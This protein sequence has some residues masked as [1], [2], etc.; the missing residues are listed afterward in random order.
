GPGTIWASPRKGITTLL[1][2]SRGSVGAMRI[3]AAALLGSMAV[4]AQPEV[5]R[6]LA[7]NSTIDRDIAAGQTHGY[8]VDAPEGAFLRVAIGG[9]DA[10]D[11]AVRINDS[12]GRVLLE[13]ENFDRSEHFTVEWIAS[14]AGPHRIHVQYRQGRAQSYRL[15]LAEVRPARE[16]DHRRIEAEA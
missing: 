13:T 10:I 9:Q 2:T 14:T 3:C 5:E 4:S 6:P 7:I 15:K 1:P 11:L 12:S 16:D 8:S